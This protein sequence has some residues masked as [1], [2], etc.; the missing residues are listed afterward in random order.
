MIT[1]S[2][3]FIIIIIKGTKA[4]EKYLYNIHY[5]LCSISDAQRCCMIVLIVF[6]DPYIMAC[7]YSNTKYKNNLIILNVLCVF[8]MPKV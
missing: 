2:M 7:L 1:K 4:F 3:T 8:P 5:S 6:T